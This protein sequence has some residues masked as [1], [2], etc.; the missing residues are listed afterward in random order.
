M[1][2]T[3]SKTTNDLVARGALVN[4]TI[5]WPSKALGEYG[6]NVTGER[7]LDEW[8]AA[9]VTTVDAVQIGASV[10]GCL[11]SGEPVI[12]VPLRPRHLAWNGASYERPAMPVGE[13]SITAQIQV[14]PAAASKRIRDA[15]EKAGSVSGAAPY[16]GITDKTLTSILRRLPE[17]KE[18]IALRGPGRPKKRSA[19]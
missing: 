18:G 7:E 17:I 3:G 9:N 11:A 16:L 19:A 14:D 2:W 13:P 10:P 15:L 4:I 6:T 12:V 1:A 8:V 5:P